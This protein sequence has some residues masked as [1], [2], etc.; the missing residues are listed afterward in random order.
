M[1]II[2]I[3]CLT[4]RFCC[5]SCTIVHVCINTIHKFTFYDS[6]M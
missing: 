4:K 2:T 6:K 3:S 5:F 1:Q